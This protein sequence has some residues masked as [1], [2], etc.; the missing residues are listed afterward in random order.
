MNWVWFVVA[1]FCEIAGCFTFWMWLRQD[2]SAWW[3][4]PGVLALTC[5]ALVLT[6]VEAQFAGRV[7]AAYG[8]VYVVSSLVWLAWVERATPAA[9]DLL[10]VALILAGS[11]VILFSPRLG[12]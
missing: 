6:R 4:L 9:A 5:F 12:G 11:S 3:L 2:R 1:A 10:G 8:G 7:F